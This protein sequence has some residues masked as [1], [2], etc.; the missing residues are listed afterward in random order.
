MS[1]L[2]DTLRVLL[3]VN[4]LL[5]L[6]LLGIWVRNYSAF[7]SK[8]TL[9]LSLFAFFLLGENAIGL[10]LFV[11][12]PILSTWIANSTAVPRPAQLAMVTLR[13][14]ETIALGCL[15]WTTWD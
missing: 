15:L 7:R 8:H 6:P 2:I 9:G 3:G 12:D 14:L 4:L 11:L 1:V 10:Y 13:A 5:L